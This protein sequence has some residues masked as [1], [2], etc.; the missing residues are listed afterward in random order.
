MLRSDSN[1][2]PFSPQ[3]IALYNKILDKI[4]SGKRDMKWA[5]K[6]C[7]RDNSPHV[8]PTLMIRYNKFVKLNHNSEEQ[9]KYLFSQ[10]KIDKK[11]KEHGKENLFDLRA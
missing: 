10:D 2:N 9:P 1:S 6:K 5:E 3:E 11:R 4:K 8:I 7:F